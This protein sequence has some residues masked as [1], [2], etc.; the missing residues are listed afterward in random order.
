MPG[1]QDRLEGARDLVKM[2][3]DVRKAIRL[4]LNALREETFPQGFG[5]LL[6]RLILV[7]LLRRALKQE[8]RAGDQ[9]GS[10]V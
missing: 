10:S 5:L 9:R 7:E 3:W 4:S 2:R 1:E 6:M 8:D